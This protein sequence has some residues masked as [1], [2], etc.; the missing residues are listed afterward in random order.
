MN[1][2]KI[3]KIT[4]PVFLFLF[5]GCATNQY[6]TAKTLKKGERQVVVAGDSYLRPIV[7]AMSNTKKGDAI[8]YSLPLG[9]SVQYNWGT[10]KKRDRTIA[11][12]VGGQLSYA[13]KYQ[14]IGSDKSTFSMAFRPQLGIAS[15]S[16][17]TSDG[18]QLWMNTPFILTKEFGQKSS[19]TVSPGCLFSLP[20]WDYSN[21]FQKAF[22][23]TSIALH[24]G[25]K[26]RFFV[27]YS[28]M[29]ARTELGNW[30]NQLSIG[31]IIKSNRNK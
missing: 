31:Y 23:N 20:G 26:N 25:E 16:G 2:F 13:T 12:S 17:Y 28:F 11:L 15:I 24:T 14:L 21:S 27:A 7:E 5:S 30:A 29:N 10:N 6:Y 22:F 19:F 8:L 3:R 4:I 9:P 18:Q 1:H